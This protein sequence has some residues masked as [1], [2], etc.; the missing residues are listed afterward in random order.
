MNSNAIREFKGEYAFLSNFARL[1]NFINLDG[2]FFWTVEHAYQAAK[3]SDLNFRRLIAQAKTP[4]EAKRI[5][6]KVP[7]RPA[8]DQMK[9]VIM[10]KLLQVKFQ[11]TNLKQKLIETYPAELVEGNWWGDHYWGVNVRTGV[12]E[13]RLGKLLMQIREE[14]LKQRRGD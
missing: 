9:D 5:G 13:N 12:G 8:W 11:Q 4:R 14:L 1:D 6:R 2:M 10:F 7:M 3:T